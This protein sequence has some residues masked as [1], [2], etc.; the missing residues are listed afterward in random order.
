MFSVCTRWLSQAILTW[1][2]SP[3]NLVR[4]CL[5]CSQRIVT[6]PTSL[7]G[8][9]SGRAQRTTADLEIGKSALSFMLTA[10]VLAM[11]NV[12]DEGPARCKYEVRNIDVRTVTQPALIMK[13]FENIFPFTFG[14]SLCSSTQTNACLKRGVT[15]GSRN[16]RGFRW[17]KYV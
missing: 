16:D 7:D 5:T 13:S 6:R 11:F 12:F 14:T 17:V 15:G 9:S 10:A 1:E 3:S 4:C 8:L 2:K